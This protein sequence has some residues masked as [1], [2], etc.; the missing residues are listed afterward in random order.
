[1]VTSSVCSAWDHDPTR[2]TAR[3]GDQVLHGVKASTYYV[4]GISAW[5]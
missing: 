2:R 5:Q 3:A 4:P 1:V